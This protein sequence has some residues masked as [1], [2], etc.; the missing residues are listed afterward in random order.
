MDM[1]VKAEVAD[2]TF[3]DDLQPEG[4]A[5]VPL[6][7]KGEVWHV[8][9]LFVGIGC[10]EGTPKARQKGVLEGLGGRQT[11]VRVQLHDA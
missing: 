3:L 4:G 9:R 1:W 11:E 5:R 8:G 7:L 6:S 10:S 2:H